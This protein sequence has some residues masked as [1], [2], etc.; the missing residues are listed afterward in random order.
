[1]RPEWITDLRAAMVPV[2][3]ALI[4]VGVGLVALAFYWSVTF[5][6]PVGWTG[7]PDLTVLIGIGGCLAILG[8]TA[9]VAEG[10]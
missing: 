8:L 5:N 7:T 6:F 9:I 4:L 2:G 1:M 10:I 3:I